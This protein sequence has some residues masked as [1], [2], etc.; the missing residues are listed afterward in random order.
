MLGPLAVALLGDVA[1]LE[2]VCHYMEADFKVSFPQARPSSFLLLPV[3]QD[4][5]LSAPSLALYPPLTC[6]ASCH[7]DNGQYL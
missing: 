6:H 4:V 7:D 3:D 1:L 5:E 2:E